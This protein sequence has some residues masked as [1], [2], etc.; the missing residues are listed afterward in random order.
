MFEAPDI[1]PLSVS[2]I[3]AAN[4]RHDDALAHTRGFGFGRGMVCVAEPNPRHSG[5]AKLKADSPHSIED[6]QRDG[7]PR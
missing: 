3:P 1:R 6:G 5:W 7:Q 2:D 4:R